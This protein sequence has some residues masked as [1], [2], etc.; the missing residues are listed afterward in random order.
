MEA[1]LN[2]EI[3]NTDGPGNLLRKSATSQHE[4]EPYEKSVRSLRGSILE[5]EKPRKMMD[6]EPTSCCF[7]FRS[8]KSKKPKKEK[9][10]EKKLEMSFVT[11]FD[12][13]RDEFH[14]PW[15]R[16]FEDYLPRYASDVQ[17]VD[18]FLR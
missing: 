1:Q 9:K 8:A 13:D 10:K 11:G 15:Q 6:N 5:K 7:C 14:E 2:S 18:S 4:S 16:I 17:W 3:P 12:N